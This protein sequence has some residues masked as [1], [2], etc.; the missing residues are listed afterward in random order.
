MVFIACA[1]SMLPFYPFSK[2][3]LSVLK[4]GPPN[5][6]LVHTNKISGKHGKLIKCYADECLLCFLPRA[7]HNQVPTDADFTID[8]RDFST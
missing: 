2:D 1:S 7:F 5:P 4:G 8:Q 6:N 3:V